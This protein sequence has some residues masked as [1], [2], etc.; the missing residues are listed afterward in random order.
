MT[1]AKFN[2]CPACSIRMVNKTCETPGCSAHPQ[3]A[4]WFT[5]SSRQAG[6]VFEGLR[7][8]I[9]RTLYAGSTTLHIEVSCPEVRDLQEKLE[10]ANKEIARLKKDLNK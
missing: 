4:V 9:A 7:N 2:Y 10:A 8:L 3:K 6:R 1:Q 5:T